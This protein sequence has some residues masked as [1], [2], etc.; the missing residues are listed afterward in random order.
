MDI[1]AQ[2]QN[3]WTPPD[4]LRDLEAAGCADAVL[5]LIEDFRTDTAQRLQRLRLTMA[6]ADPAAF[7]R[8]AH[9]IKGSALQMGAAEV[10]ATA[11]S[12]ELEGATMPAWAVQ[13][14][15]DKLQVQFET[16]CR[17]MSA[18]SARVGK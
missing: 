9:S 16:V 17:Q 10:S 18:Y 5:E 11:K 7:R 4:V 14:A 8:E 15:I 6:G 12:L 1:G 13:A 2:D 3:S